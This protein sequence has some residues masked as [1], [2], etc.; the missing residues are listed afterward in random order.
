MWK[1][2]KSA[3]EKMIEGKDLKG[4]IDALGDKDSS[5]VAAAANALGDLGDP[6]AGPP[7]GD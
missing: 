1:T 6:P 2:I 7:N 5:I 4:L 3:I